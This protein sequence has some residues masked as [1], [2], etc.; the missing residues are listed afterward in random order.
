MSD[1]GV[2]PQRRFN[3]EARH[4]AFAFASTRSVG[5]EFAGRMRA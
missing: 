2:R 3:D 4:D 5:A 1:G